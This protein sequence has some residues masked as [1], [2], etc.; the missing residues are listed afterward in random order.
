MHDSILTA[1][2]TKIIKMKLPYIDEFD[3]KGTSVIS[4]M[5]DLVVGIF[6]HL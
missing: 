2:K 3:H 6:E 4:V 5:R 1:T